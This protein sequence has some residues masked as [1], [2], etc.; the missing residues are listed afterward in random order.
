M[1]SK[2]VLPNAKLTLKDAPQ[3]RHLAKMNYPGWSIHGPW[4]FKD[5]FESTCRASNLKCP[6]IRVKD[7]AKHHSSTGE[8]FQTRQLPF[9]LGHLPGLG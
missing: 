6:L 1:M 8:A 5:S 4:L 2:I 3:V 9:W 7:A